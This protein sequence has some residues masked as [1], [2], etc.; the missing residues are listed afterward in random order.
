MDKQKEIEEMANIIIQAS[1]YG[2]ECETCS[3]VESVKDA[4]ECC[5]CLKALYNAGYRKIPENAVVL[6]REEYEKLKGERE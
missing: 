4:T 1:C 6:T 3:W 5:V 2:S